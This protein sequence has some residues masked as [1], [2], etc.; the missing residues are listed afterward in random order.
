MTTL[1][2]LPLQFKVLF[3]G[4]LV[5]IGAGLLMAGLQIMLTHGM[6]NAFASGPIRDN[7]ENNAATSGARPMGAAHW[8]LTA[9]RRAEGSR[10]LPIPGTA[11]RWSSWLS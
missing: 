6:A 9:S 4:F 7:V 2:R 1:G 8:L 3:T 11:T 10:R 5:A